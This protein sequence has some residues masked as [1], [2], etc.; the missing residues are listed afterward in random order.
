MLAIQYNTNSKSTGAESKDMSQLRQDLQKV[1]EQHQRI[2]TDI[3]K[4]DQLLYKYKNPA[5]QENS[6][7]LMTEELDRIKAFGGMAPIEGKGLLITIDEIVD[8]MD[9]ELASLSRIFDDDLRYVTNEL[10]GAG[11]LAMAINDNRMTAQTA[12]R[13]VGE[14]I[15]VNTIIVKLPFEI[16]VI[17][18]PEVLESAMKLKG[19]EE[20][21]N[22]F[23][24]R[25]STQKL[26]H[27]T[28]PA[29]DKKGFTQYMKPLKEEA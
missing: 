7:K 29:F 13:D 15:Q 25:F 22:V 4:Y 10:F 8:I 24:K 16:K 28:V 9:D 27:I 11:A 2:L 23:N 17:G 20:Y 5:N 21:F 1:M 18:D 26:D 6:L 3:S 14:D 19:F 12:I